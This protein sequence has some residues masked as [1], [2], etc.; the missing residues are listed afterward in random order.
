MTRPADVWSSAY[1][2]ARG[3]LVVPMLFGGPD[4][5][6]WEWDGKSWHRSDATPPSRRQ[7]Y[8][9]TYDNARRQVV[10][11]GGQGGNKGPYFGELSAWDGVRWLPVEQPAERP[12]ARGG[13]TLLTDARNAGLFY[14]G[15]YNTR[16]LG[17]LWSFEQG[18]WRRLSAP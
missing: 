6:T 3:V 8:G 12:E 7:T 2:A 9:L 13:G 5:G 16:L 10:L 1:D 14:F 4:A 17:D 15:G 11:V 18:L